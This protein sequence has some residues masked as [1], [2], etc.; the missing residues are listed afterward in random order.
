MKRQR[1]AEDKATTSRSRSIEHRTH[2]MD[3]AIH[4]SLNMAP[5]PPP[6]MSFHPPADAPSRAPPPEIIANSGWALPTLATGRWYEPNGGKASQVAA[7]QLAEIRTLKEH[8]G[9][10]QSPAFL[11]N[12]TFS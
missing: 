5:V 7:A 10:P 11:S 8:V 12:S 9:E 2:D 4:P 3:A 6:A 1:L